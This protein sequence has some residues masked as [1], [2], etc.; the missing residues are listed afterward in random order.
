MSNI[1][2]KNAVNYKK[3]TVSVLP[4]ENIVNFEVLWRDELVA[5][6]SVDF[7][8]Q[9]VVAEQ[10][11]TNPLRKAFPKGT[12]NLKVSDVLDFL[13]SRCFP[14][15]RADRDK[16]LESI[17]LNYYRP[18]HI[19]RKTHGVQFDDFMWVRFEGESLKHDDIKVRN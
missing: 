2:G 1:R 12:D 4:S 13:E 19:V 17:E 10:F 11:T 7:K 8:R 15:E 14:R 5:K 9:K 6:V 18:L 3:D 16:V